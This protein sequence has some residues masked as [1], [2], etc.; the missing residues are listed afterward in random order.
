MIPSLQNIIG[1]TERWVDTDTICAVVPMASFC[2]NLQIHPQISIPC[3]L[4][5]IITYGFSA[6]VCGLTKIKYYGF[7]RFWN[8]SSFGENGRACEDTFNVLCEKDPS[9]CWAVFPISLFSLNSVLPDGPWMCKTS[10]WLQWPRSP[11]L[12][13]ACFHRTFRDSLHFFSLFLGTVL[14]TCQSLFLFCYNYFL[15]SK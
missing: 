4:N 2:C 5:L 14:C 11:L 15:V 1:Q 9:S 13:Y 8:A 7:C 3:R 10:G 12:K 6:C